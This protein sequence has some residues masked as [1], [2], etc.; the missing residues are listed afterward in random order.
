MTIVKPFYKNR[1]KIENNVSGTLF[2]WR[3]T[4]PR[5]PGQQLPCFIRIHAQRDVEEQ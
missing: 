4:R 1:I 5:L 2:T 3:L